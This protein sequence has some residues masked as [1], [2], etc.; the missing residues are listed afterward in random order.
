MSMAA[1]KISRF[2]V[3]FTALA[4]LDKI[5]GYIIQMMAQRLNLGRGLGSG[6]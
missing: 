6:W 2:F 1:T 4:L 3:I 5:A